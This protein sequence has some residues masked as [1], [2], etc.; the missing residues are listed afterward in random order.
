MSL[1]SYSNLPEVA[2]HAQQQL[3]TF[4]NNPRANARLSF[5]VQV[6]LVVLIAW[7]TARLTWTFIPAPVSDN[8][9]LPSRNQ[10]AA[11]QQTQTADLRSVSRLHLFGKAEVTILTKGAPIQAPET[12]LRLILRGVYASNDDADAL[13]II[14]E[15]GKKD[16][17]YRIGD[18]VAGGAK[19]HQVYEDRVILQRDGRLETLKLKF[20][21]AKINL[22]PET[23][24]SAYGSSR[25]A[26]NTQ[27]RAT[28]RIRRMLELVKQDPSKLWKQIRITPK[29]GDNNQMIGVTFS[30]ND[31]L[32]M[33]D[34]G[35]RPND[36]ITSIN[37][38]SVSD[39]GAINTLTGQLQSLSVVN[40]DIMRNGTPQSIT[41]NLN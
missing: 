10:G 40:L 6:L 24:R 39:P 38:T 36:V 26:S 5:W 22:L 18:A 25:Q 13:A 29:M 41:I 9:V 35:L 27:K 33:R 16:T 31:Q 12:H 30:H 1:T 32:L 2:Q 20:K 8:M 17:S 19:L 4:L 7:S 21:L 37:G 3:Q 28:P 11:I 14:A 34:L 23:S 15:Q